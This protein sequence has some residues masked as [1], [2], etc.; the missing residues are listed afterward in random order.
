[1]SDKMKEQSLTLSFDEKRLELTNTDKNVSLQS[2]M[3]F[4][5][6]KKYDPTVW[7]ARMLEIR[8]ESGM[9]YEDARNHMVTIYPT[10]TI[11]GLTWFKDHCK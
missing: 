7:V 8:K 1:M 9:S 5:G 10:E 6:Q 11:P 3:K 2:D 4:E